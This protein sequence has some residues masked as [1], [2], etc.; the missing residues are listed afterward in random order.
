MLCLVCYG[1]KLY[2][3]LHPLMCVLLMCC[4][5]I[6]FTLKT[7][8][9]PI[10]Q[11]VESTLSVFNFKYCEFDISN[12]N[13]VF[14]KC[15]DCLVAFLTSSS[16]ARLYRRRVPRLTSDNFTSQSGMTMTSV[17]AGHSILTQTQPV[18]SE[19]PQREPSPVRPHQESRALPTELLR[20]PNV[21][22]ML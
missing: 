19:R 21:K 4:N 22:K 10:F 17:S 14:S 7:L 2:H 18:G 8:K 11:R 3:L 16:T 1:N 20:P 5:N 13:T 12:P 6:F 15:Q 9:N